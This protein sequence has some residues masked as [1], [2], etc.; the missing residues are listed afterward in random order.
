M[1]ITF[2][3][4][5]VQYQF[6]HYHITLFKVSLKCQQIGHMIMAQLFPD[7]FLLFKSLP[8]RWED[9]VFSGQKLNK[10]RKTAWKH[11]YQANR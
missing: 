11:L 9:S 1:C 4:T 8:L 10:K 7:C 5:R 2:N 6:K 3:L